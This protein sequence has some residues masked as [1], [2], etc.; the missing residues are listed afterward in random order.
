[1]YCVYI[2]ALH[3]FPTFKY[4]KEKPIQKRSQFF[5]FLGFQVIPRISSWK[6]RTKLQIQ[7]NIDMT[8]PGKILMHHTLLLTITFTL[9]ID[10]SSKLKSSFL[11][12]YF[13]LHYEFFIS[14]KKTYDYRSIL[15]LFLKCPALKLKYFDSKTK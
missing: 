13:S 15:R 1:M 14:E 4:L 5:F 2:S 9:N 10:P 12:S 6:E 3:Q 8:S 7:W 11:N